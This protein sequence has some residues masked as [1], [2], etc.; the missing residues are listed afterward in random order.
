MRCAVIGS[1]IIHSLSPAIHTAAYQA[2][3]LDWRYERHQL[4][5]DQVGDFVAGLGEGWRGLSV[6]MPCKAA[7]VA[8]GQPD[9]LVAE[10]GVANTVVFDGPPGTKATTR[11]HNSDVL[12]VENCLVEAG[13]VPGEPISL[14]GTGA[15]ARS[16]LYA[17]GRLAFGPVCLRGR[18]PAKR[19]ALA[20]EAAKWG[21]EVIGEASAAVLISTVPAPVALEW[22]SQSRPPRLVFDV[23]YDP[24]PTRLA[25]AA[26][27]RGA[28]VISG[29][30][31]L[32]A[33]AVEQIVW[34]TGERLEAAL[35][36]TAAQAELAKRA[37][38]AQ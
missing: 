19:Q 22:A 14:F 20:D 17:L 32:V 1:P 27:A 26:Q 28:A 2:L 30:D 5:A 38:R 10:L 6:T 13:V 8:L 12:G 35:L 33:Q 36:R 29:L 34:M 9:A 18:D 31:L 15:T 25:A 11:V 37:R 24:W 4:S 21:V 16:C 3:G 7:V 23:L